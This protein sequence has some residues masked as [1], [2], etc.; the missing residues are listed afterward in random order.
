MYSTVCV[1]VRGHV[2]GGDDEV[3][4][5]E[6]MSHL[7]Y[8]SPLKRLLEIGSD[9][10]SVKPVG[11][12]MAIIFISDAI[13]IITVTIHNRVEEKSVAPRVPSRSVVCAPQKKR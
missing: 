3:G 9:K 10:L 7:F 8:L 1:T 5:M 11:A 2:C 13:V 6:P 4:P 12:I